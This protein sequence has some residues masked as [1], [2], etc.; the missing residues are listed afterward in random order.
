MINLAG[1]ELPSYS[2]DGLAERLQE[3][4]VKIATDSFEPLKKQKKLFHT[5]SIGKQLRIFWK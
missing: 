3:F 1:S 5:I 4:D 2:V